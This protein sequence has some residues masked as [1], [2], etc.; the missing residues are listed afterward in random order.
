MFNYS[1]GLEN[2]VFVQEK[3]KLNPQFYK[4]IFATKKLV[5]PTGGYTLKL[6]RNLRDDTFN[7]MFK[8]V[9]DEKSDKWMDREG[10]SS[11]YPF[12]NINGKETPLNKTHAHYSNDQNI[13]SFFAHRSVL[14]NVK[15]RD[16]KSATFGIK[17]ISGYGQIKEQ[18]WMSIY[19]QFET[20][21]D[22]V[23]IK[24]DDILDIKT[25]NGITISIKSPTNFDTQGHYKNDEM[26]VQKSYTHT[27]LVPRELKRIGKNITVFDVFIYNDIKNNV[28][29]PG[30]K[31]TGNDSSLKE[32]EIK[33]TSF[34]KSLSLVVND[35]EHINDNIDGVIK[36]T[37]DNIV[38]WLKELE[39][40]NKI[41]NHSEVKYISSFNMF[42]QTSYNYEK[43]E[44]VVGSSS[45]SRE[46]EIIP[47]SLKGGYYRESTLG[48]NEI[49]NKIKVLQSFSKL[50]PI[51][52]PDIGAVEMTISTDEAD[53]G[54]AIHRI[55][56]SI[57]LKQ[58]DYIYP[59]K[60]LERLSKTCEDNNE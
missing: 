14:D 19:P 13:N 48:I 27:L 36:E 17:D 12:V 59:L 41:H 52:Q 4:S 1:G 23:K 42:N 7:A 32:G 30:T 5:T 47:Y 57:M 33:T 10:V 8:D 16:L 49:Y 15:F 60:G 39:K 26:L 25:V 51:L 58:K 6:Q 29:M 11:V 56:P 50:N 34:K 21:K 40:N 9:K 28:D 18:Y 31:N 45:S 44:S 35:I 54:K 53:H 24:D 46:G 3:M 20:I 55:K 38:S 37:K 22:S 2:I 43:G